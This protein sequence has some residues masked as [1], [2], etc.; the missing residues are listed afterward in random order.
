MKKITTYTTDQLQEVWKQFA[1]N[2]YSVVYSS[3]GGMTWQSP[4]SMDTG[5]WNI[6]YYEF[7]S[8]DKPWIFAFLK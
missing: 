7:S 2:P 1:I 6:Q 3:D 5:K 8:K 4:P